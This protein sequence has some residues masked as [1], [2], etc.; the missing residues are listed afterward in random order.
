[1][2][3]IWVGL[4]DLAAALLAGLILAV[5]ECYSPSKLASLASVTTYHRF[6][7]VATISDYLAEQL[8]IMV[9]GLTI[10]KTLNAAVTWHKMVARVLKTGKAVFAVQLLLLAG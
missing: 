10:E 6:R 2:T 5:T 1:M 9:K 3:D 7:W 4:R 8:N